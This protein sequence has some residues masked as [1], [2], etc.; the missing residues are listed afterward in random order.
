NVPVYMSAS[1]Q[2]P[3]VPYD[4]EISTYVDDVTL[5]NCYV[6]LV[7]NIPVIDVNNGNKI[8]LMFLERKMVQGQNPVSVVRDVTLI[9]SKGV[10]QNQEIEVSDVRN[11]TLCEDVTGEVACD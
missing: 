6:V 1:D 9:V 8:K 5:Q 2:S 10:L 7:K 3:Y 11:Q 4:Y